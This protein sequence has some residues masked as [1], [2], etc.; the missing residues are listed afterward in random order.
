MRPDNLAGDT[1]LDLPVFEHVLAELK[2]REGYEP[3]LV[4]HLP[5]RPRHYARFHW[6]DEAVDL[7]A[8][9]EQGRTR[10]APC[11]SHRNIRTGFSGSP[12]VD[13][14]IRIMMQE[15]PTPYLLRRQELP[16]MYYYNCVID[17]TRPTTILSMKSM[18]GKK[19]SCLT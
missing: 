1:V 3:H 9:N 2:D 16:G 13:T 17:V 18:T 19:T 5:G 11:R 14:L 6:I 8:A 15:H 7:L 4:V 10:F 12:P